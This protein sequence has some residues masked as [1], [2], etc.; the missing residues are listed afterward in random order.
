MGH[1]S[2]AGSWW[3]HFL[4]EQQHVTFSVVLETGRERERERGKERKRKEERERGYIP[5]KIQLISK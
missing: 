1:L 4:I 5:Q 3:Q 2:D